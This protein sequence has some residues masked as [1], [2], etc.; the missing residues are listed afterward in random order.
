MN[1]AIDLNNLFIV[2][3][4]LQLLNAIE[5]AEH[6]KLE[7][8][9]LVI[10]H[11]SLEANRTQIDAIRSLYEWKEVIDI[12]DSKNS[13]ILKYINLVKYLKKDSYKYIFIPKLEVVPKLVIANV[14]KEKVFLL[15]DGVLT[16]SIYKNKKIK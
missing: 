15:D 2:G 8:N 12:E 1:L 5:A 7:N 10:V 9:I 6:F 11:R 14:E 16:I 4:P 3:T 13:S